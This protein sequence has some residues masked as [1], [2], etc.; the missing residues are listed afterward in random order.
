MEGTGGER[1]GRRRRCGL[2]RLRLLWLLRLARLSV[3][4][5]VRQRL[6]LPTKA[7]ARDAGHHFL[8]AAHQLE[9]A[10]AL[11]K[12]HSA[13]ASGLHHR[14][15]AGG[16]STRPLARWIEVPALHPAE[17]ERAGGRPVP[18]LQPRGVHTSTQREREAATE[19]R[20]VERA[21]APPRARRRIA[22][23]QDD[24]GGVGDGRH[25]VSVA[26]VVALQVEQRECVLPLRL[27]QLHLRL[28]LAEE[29]ERQLRSERTQLLILRA[30][31][32]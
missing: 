27:L 26:Q 19:P 1:D 20:R 21:R 24:K 11:T 22:G 6:D 2:L 30:C 4:R 7:D 16:G 12:S 13:R 29:R 32:R 28:R 15:I 23:A 25:L 10:R 9:R 18:D 31:G 3:P 17:C 5:R 8:Q 14:R